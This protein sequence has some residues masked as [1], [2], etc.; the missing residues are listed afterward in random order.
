MDGSHM[1][2][3]PGLIAQLRTS[4]MAR[5]RRGDEVVLAGNAAALK[6]LLSLPICLLLLTL[7]L[8]IVRAL[9]NEFE[10]SGLHLKTLKLFS[11]LIFLLAI[12]V[13]L[14]LSLRYRFVLR[15]DQSKLLITET[16]GSVRVITL[17]PSAIRSITINR[18][19][20]VITHPDGR[21]VKIG[22]LLTP[23]KKL[24]LQDLLET[25]RIER[26]TISC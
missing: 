22:R 9:L 1:P 18:W 14:S 26:G 25:L 2:G 21:V 15:L 24:L 23:D 7:F 19:F 13:V 12:S 11:A 3:L 10:M 17:D 16:I 4:R 5:L 8:I 6:L 20:V